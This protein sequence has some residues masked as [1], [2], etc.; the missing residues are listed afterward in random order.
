M[1]QNAITET[2]RQRRQ[3]FKSRSNSELNERVRQLRKEIVKL[4][5]EKEPN[6]KLHNFLMNELL[7]AKEKMYK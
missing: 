3:N 1:Y 7:K 5:F 4:S 2:I 6:I